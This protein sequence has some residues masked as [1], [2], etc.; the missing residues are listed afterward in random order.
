M[1]THAELCE[2]ARAVVAEALTN[3]AA[4]KGKVALALEVLRLPVVVT[5]APRRSGS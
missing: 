3:T 5:A 1:A 2:Q 4:D